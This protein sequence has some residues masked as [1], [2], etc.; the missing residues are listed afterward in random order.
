MINRKLLA[1]SDQGSE[2]Q[3]CTRQLGPF[4]WEVI[5]ASDFCSARALIDRHD[6]Y[7]GMVYMNHECAEINR[8]EELLLTD[9]PIEWIA[10]AT[11]ADWQSASF[12]Q[13]IGD[14]F[15]DYHTLPLDI[16]RLAVTL[17]HAYGKVEVKRRLIIHHED[18]GEYQM[19][20]IS[21]AMQKLYRDLQ[22]IQF[23]DAP[24]L[25]QGESGTGKELAAQAVHQNSNCS[26]GP[27]V[28]VNCGS[29]PTHLVQTELFGHEKGAFTGAFRRKI[30]RFETAAG[31]TIFLDEIGDL[32]LDLQVT[33]L[34]FLEEKTIQRV[35]STEPVS[36]NARVIAATH[37]NLEE[38]VALGRFREDLYYRINV[39]RLDIPP[40]RSR[41]S[42]F[43][44]LAREY[45]EKFSQGGVTVAKGFS[46]QALHTMK[47]YHWPGNV[48]E[49][50]NR[51]RRAV[52]MSENRL[53]TPADLGLERRL[54]ARYQI[55]LDRA[56]SETELKLIRR[57]LSLSNNNVS[58]AARQLGVS[59][60]T[61]YRLMNK[62]QIEQ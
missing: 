11:S 13:L 33:I 17:G 42:D 53:I 44:L 20:G 4:G 41:D 61:L 49:L 46:K 52:V 24:I 23:S 36:V 8:L 29:I 40:L 3:A 12:G 6:F 51:V 31:G 1:Y 19:I 30:G 55:N 2:A 47:N 45:F 21:P 25:I 14:L 57:A 18:T 35:G 56:R 15:Y 38:A 5:T 27:F 58:E 48:R 43:E 10:V 9:Q 37:V 32:P 26:G 34:R 60:V 50:I 22:K 62:L 39:L 28:A 16:G 59:R 7:I 54:A